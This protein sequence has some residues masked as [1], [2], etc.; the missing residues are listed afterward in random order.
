MNFNMIK[1]RRPV[2]MAEVEEILKETKTEN[3]ELIGFIKKFVNL[4]AKEAE[5]MKDELGAL[6]ML[7]MKEEYIVKIIDLLPEDSIDLNKIFNEIT[8]DENERT[9]ILDIVKKYK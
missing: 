7:K 5:K 2:S 4:S 9:Q 8:L 3:K 1:T 6:N